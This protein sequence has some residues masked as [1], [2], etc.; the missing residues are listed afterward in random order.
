MQK[1]SKH[2]NSRD[3]KSLRPATRLV[4]GGSLR[5]DFGETSE[6]MFLTQGY[7]YDTME[8]AEKRFK[9]EE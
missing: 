6:A 4:H 7:L 8:A 5:S 1:P 9:G 3:P 2:Y